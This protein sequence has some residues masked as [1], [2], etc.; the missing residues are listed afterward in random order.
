MSFLNI[1]DA[2]PNCWFKLVKDSLNTLKLTAVLVVTCASSRWS[3]PACCSDIPKFLENSAVLFEASIIEAR[4]AA[5][6]A[7]GKA[8]LSAGLILLKNA[9]NL[10]SLLSMALS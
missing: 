6:A 9:L 10:F 7:A 2:V 8:S 4:T 3:F 5:V 1:V